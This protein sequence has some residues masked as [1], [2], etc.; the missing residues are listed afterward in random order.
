MIPCCR[1]VVDENRTT[2]EKH[3]DRQRAKTNDLPHSHND[4]QPQPHFR[5]PH[6]ADPSKMTSE[7]NMSCIVNVCA[8]LFILEA[9]LTSSFSYEYLFKNQS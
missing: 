2:H 3:E 4:Q 7:V 5:P 1:G 6:A 9:Y 8:G